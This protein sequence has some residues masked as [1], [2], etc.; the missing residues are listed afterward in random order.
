M[1]FL[2]KV[3][4]G[5]ERIVNMYDL[6][7]NQI[8]NK[9][10]LIELPANRGYFKEIGVSKN[11][12]NLGKLERYATSIIYVLLCYKNISPF[13]K[14]ISDEIFNFCLGDPVEVFQITNEGNIIKKILGNNILHGENPC[15]FVN[16]NTWQAMRL[17]PG[18]QYALLTA[19][20]SPSFDPLDFY[21]G[22]KNELINMFP[23]FSSII[24]ELSLDRNL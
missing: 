4:T 2:T 23:T 9:L 18:G 14:V 19:T 17:T 10:D 3:Q 22:K 20:N 1:V 13:N 21:M 6:D 8:I 11:R 7:L 15:L 16:G 12:V 24:A 5:I